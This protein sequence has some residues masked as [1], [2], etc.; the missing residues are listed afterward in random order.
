MHIAQLI[1]SE[2]FYAVLN[3][4]LFSQIIIFITLWLFF[5]I[6]NDNVKSRM[7]KLGAE[8]AFISVIFGMLLVGLV[9]KITSHNLL[10]PWLLSIICFFFVPIYFLFQSIFKK[11][12]GKPEEYKI[13]RSVYIISLSLFVVVLLIIGR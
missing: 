10:L 13:I 6:K 7:Y 11:I 2:K 1:F 9:L 8:Y 5:K 12:Q 3:I 4:Y